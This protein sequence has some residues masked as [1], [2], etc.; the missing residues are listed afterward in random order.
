MP[1]EMK[2]LKG[3]AAKA[4]PKA[5]IA[6]ERMYFTADGTE[7]VGEGHPGAAILAVAEGHRLHPDMVKRF[8]ITGGKLAASGENKALK[9][10]SN[11]GA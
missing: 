5:K 8:K 3:E 9:G 1:L 10:A 2:T 7:L 4:E 11:K 6:G